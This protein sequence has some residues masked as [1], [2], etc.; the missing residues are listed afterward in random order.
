VPT[1]GRARDGAL[2]AFDGVTV[3]RQGAVVLDAVSVAIPDGG[4]TALVGPSGS[5]KSTMLRCCNRLEVPVRGTVLFR[6]EDVATLD[7]RSLRRRVAMLF[8]VP[9]PFAGSV[10]D[11]LRAGAPSLPESQA[12]ALLDRVGMPPDLVDRVADTLS[13]GEAQ[14]LCLA[15]ALATRPEVLLADEPTSALD[16]AAAD[17]LERL[18][19][20]LADGGTPVVWVTHDPAQVH[21]LADHVVELRVGRVASTG[22]ERS[23]AGP[24]DEPTVR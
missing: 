19:R 2:F 13:G 21:R 18:A 3:A 12:G 23:A 14:R 6:G 4:V 17:V 7:P 24:G 8:Q 1:P 5:G 9:V 10:L 11:N 22:D 20:E 15:R 16:R